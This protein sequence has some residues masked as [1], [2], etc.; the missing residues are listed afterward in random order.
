MEIRDSIHR[1]DHDAVNARKKGRLH[2][3]VYNVK[4]P[5]HL[6]H[7]DTN[8]KFVRWYF[9]IIGVIDGFSR[10]PVVIECQNDNKAETVLQSWIKGVE[11]YG[12]PSR[13]RSD[14]GGET[15]LVADYMITRRGANRGSMI[16]GKSTHNQR[17]ERLWRDGF[18]GV[19]PVL[20][21]I[22][23]HGGQRYIRP[24]Q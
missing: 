16:T 4:G 17:I 24:I 14:K 1:V 21:T 18:E 20:S 10:L 2:Q 6:W 3:R 23:F 15:V 19:G 11:M 9:V 7:M 5:N 12:L 22:L 13:V 8:H